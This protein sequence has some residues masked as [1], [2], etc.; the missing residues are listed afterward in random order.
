[1]S[2]DPLLPAPL[3]PVPRARRALLAGLALAGALGI[4]A[5]A[6]VFTPKSI[7]ISQERLQAL[8]AERFPVD[9]RV[10]DAID[11]TVDTPHL[12]LDP[13]RNRIAVEMALRA[14]TGSAFTGRLAGSM[15]VSQALRF[16]P[17]DNTIR[18]ADVQLERFVIE[19]LPAVFQRQLDRY[20]RPLARQLL[21]DQVLY[22]LRPKDVAALEGRGV[23][24]GDLRVTRSGIEIA[25]V[26][27]SP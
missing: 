22:T 1:M 8:I 7:E 12:E 9:R 27:V 11:V 10:L 4:A 26:P 17:R 3:G 24:P 21:E 16:E 13:E 20:G 15:R 5:C 6:G 14:E 2:V 18:L 23:R 25:L 19:G